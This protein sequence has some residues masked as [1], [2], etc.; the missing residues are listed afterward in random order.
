MTSSTMSRRRSHLGVDGA[1][2]AVTFLCAVLGMAIEI[3]GLPQPPATALSTG[4]SAIA[5]VTLVGGRRY[6]RSAAGVGIICASVTGALGYIPT[7]LLLAPLIGL[8]YWVSLTQHAFAA[9]AFT[10]SAIAAVIGGGIVDDAL[11]SPTLLR[12]VGVAVWLLPSVFAGRMTRA[13]QLYLQL[14]EARAD[15]AERT[16]DDEV[17]RRVTEERVRIARELH[18]VVAHHL[19]VA[20]AQAGTAAH[21][22]DRNP[23]RAHE[24]LDG[25][26]T[27]T[28]AALRELKVAVTLLRNP[29]DDPSD[30]TGLHPA[31]G[32]AQ[33]PALLDSCRSVGIEVTAATSG[34]PRD[35]PPLVD[36]TVFRIVQEALTNVTK[37]AITPKVRIDLHYGHNDFRCEI[38]NTGSPSGRSANQGYGHIGMRERAHAV[39]GEI[40]VG[41]S[42]R[43]QYTVTLAVPLDS[44]DG[45]LKQSAPS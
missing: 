10:T 2:A 14:V 33:L 31:P 45:E 21:L 40:T 35:L 36:V 39:G 26:S 15:D 9:A 30:D 3:P 5:S 8:L 37:H 43:G 24:L 18:D 19:A 12:T 25:L 41:P 44:W 1:I 6:P 17:H 27:S 22:W 11:E 42:G 4:L 34:Y 7:P 28:S 16:R 38:V 23:V 13:R 29:S 20:N 32:L